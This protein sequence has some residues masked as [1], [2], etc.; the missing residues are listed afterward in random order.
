MKK[1][2]NRIVLAL[3]LCVLLTTACSPYEMKDP[4]GARI[5]M[6]NEGKPQK[7]DETQGDAPAPETTAEPVSSSRPDANAPR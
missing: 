4:T 1:T 6:L 5:I 3:C 7:T 2:V